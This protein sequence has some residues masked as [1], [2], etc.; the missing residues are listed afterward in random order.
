[1]L[2]DRQ[3]LFVEKYVQCLN[4]TLAAIQ[5]GYSE[6]TAR[7]IGSENLTKPYIRAEIE[8]LLAERGMGK[9]EVLA[10]LADHAAGDMTRFIKLVGQGEKASLVQ[11]LEGATRRGDMRLVKKMKFGAKGEVTIELYD[12]QRALA[13]LAQVHKLI[14]RGGGDDSGWDDDEADG[15]D[16]APRPVGDEEILIEAQLTGGFS[17]S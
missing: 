2:N 16:E 6:K 10:R 15:E 4:A 13:L 11:D 8:R 12:S 17:A 3:R 7:F 14:G 5:A 1:M 9:N